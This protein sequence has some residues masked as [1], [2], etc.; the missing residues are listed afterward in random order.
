MDHQ[1]DSQLFEND[2]LLLDLLPPDADLSAS[3]DPVVEDVEGR[4]WRVRARRGGLPAGASV[5]AVLATLAL[6]L[7]AAVLVTA[8]L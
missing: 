6:L 8:A 7:I 3:S 5:W 4:L 2:D 1:P